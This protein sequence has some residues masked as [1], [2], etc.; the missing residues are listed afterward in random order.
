MTA[1]SAGSREGP[2]QAGIEAPLLLDGDG[3]V[4]DRGGRG[5]GGRRPAHAATL[6]PLAK[7]ELEIAKH[8]HVP[9][10]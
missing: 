3:E 5:R 10:G 6:G 1:G 2:L 8:L 7:V 9:S 4:E